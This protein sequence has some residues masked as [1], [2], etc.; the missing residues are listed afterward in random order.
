MPGLSGYLTKVYSALVYGLVFWV[1][2][3]AVQQY[4]AGVLLSSGLNPPFWD[5]FGLSCI[6][7]VLMGSLYVVMYMADT[8]WRKLYYCHGRRLEPAVQPPV[9]PRFSVEE[10]EEDC[11][12]AAGE[13][14]RTCRPAEEQEHSLVLRVT[15]SALWYYMYTTG[16]GVFCMAYTLHGAHWVSSLCLC[17]GSLF[18]GIWG[19]LHSGL[20][21]TVG[22]RIAMGLLAVLNV[23]SVCVCA[24]LLCTQ[25]RPLWRSWV[26]EI[27]CPLLAPFWLL[28]SKVKMTPLNMPKQSMVLFGLPFTSMISAGYLSMY[29]PLQECAAAESVAQGLVVN[30][31]MNATTGAWTPLVT[32]QGLLGQSAWG[33]LLCGAIVP[34]LMYCGFVLYASSFQKVDTQLLCGNSLWLVLTTRLWTHAGAGFASAAGMA[35]L[36][37]FAAMLFVL[38]LHFEGDTMREWRDVYGD[39]LLTGADDAEPASSAPACTTTHSPSHQLKG[40]A[41]QH[42]GAKAGPQTL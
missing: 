4:Q 40:V 7:N 16:W 26:V 1:L 30:G 29:I 18:C 5:N 15:P 24:S 41:S 10:V 31:S 38:L 35:L 9:A 8:A 23:A 21:D 22:K 34:G 20:A 36:G 14:A 3:M 42:P 2:A 17:A 39:I 37:W 6:S 32:E 19:V 27:A 33:L 13:G 25:Q 28:E 12:V 11:E